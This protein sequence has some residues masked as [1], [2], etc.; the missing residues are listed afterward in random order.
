MSCWLTAKGA[1][2]SAIAF[3]TRATNLVPSCAV[4]HANAMPPQ[5]GE[6][7]HS[8]AP[9]S[10]TGQPKVRPRFSFPDVCAIVTALEG[11]DFTYDAVW[12]YP[13]PHLEFVVLQLLFQL[14][15]SHR[16]LVLWYF[17]FAYK[18]LAPGSIIGIESLGVVPSFPLSRVTL[19]FRQPIDEYS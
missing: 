2:G 14:T 10:G 4:V 8:W 3:T 7:P 11:S 19:D 16:L 13:Q 6:V 12:T 9:N 5:S 15:F 17:T 1:N 18:Y